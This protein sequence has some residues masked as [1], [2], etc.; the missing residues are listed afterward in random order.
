MTLVVEGGNWRLA[1][2]HM[3][4]VAGTPGTHPLPGA[5]E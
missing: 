2:I 4:F 5:P 3:S 1:G